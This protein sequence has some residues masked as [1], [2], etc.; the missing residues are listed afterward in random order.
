MKSKILIIIFLISCGNYSKKAMNNLNIKNEK[1]ETNKDLVTLKNNIIYPCQKHSFTKKELKSF[2]ISGYIYDNIKRDVLIPKDIILQIQ[3]FYSKDLEKS[4]ELGYENCDDLDKVFDRFVYLNFSTENS[5]FFIDKNIS[6]N[7]LKFFS[8]LGKDRQKKLI[9]FFKKDI[10]T[11]LKTDI[12]IKE[13]SNFIL[14][15]PDIFINDSLMTFYFIFAKKRKNLSNII[16]SLGVCS[17]YF[18]KDW[19][20][21]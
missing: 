1:E 19:Q 18:N 10:L 14:R 5:S 16:L 21:L 9:K 7:I 12:K 6:K 20:E 3:K 15:A 11:F 2:I 4:L 17:V 8:S 13:F